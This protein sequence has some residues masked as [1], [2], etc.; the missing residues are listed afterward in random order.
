MLFRSAGPGPGMG[1]PEGRIAGGTAGVVADR[2]H[3]RTAPVV[4]GQGLP[5]V[6]QPAG[7]LGKLGRAEQELPEAQGRGD[8]GHH[9]G[10]AAGPDDQKGL[11][12]HPT[13]S[14]PERGTA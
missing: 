8:V 2:D 4:R 9:P 12:A 13:R 7:R 14:R 1:R 6:T 3:V 5:G 11:S 10:L